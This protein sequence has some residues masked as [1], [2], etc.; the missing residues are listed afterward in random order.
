[1]IAISS[2]CYIHPGVPTV[3]WYHFNPDANTFL[4]LSGKGILRRVSERRGRR[5]KRRHGNRDR[6]RLQRRKRRKVERAKKITMR[7]VP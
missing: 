2:I 1:M 7:R 5:G 6:N 4:S 3:K